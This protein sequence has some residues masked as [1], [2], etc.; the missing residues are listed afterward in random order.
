M[1]RCVLLR[2]IVLNLVGVSTTT[3]GGSDYFSFVVATKNANHLVG[4]I[5]THYEFQHSKD[6]AFF[7]NARI[8]PKKVCFFLFSAIF[9]KKN[10]IEN[11]CVTK[12]LYYI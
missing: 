9:L 11:Q 12:F 6:R 2:F 10:A 7:I 4:V 1:T 5:V 8:S 3:H